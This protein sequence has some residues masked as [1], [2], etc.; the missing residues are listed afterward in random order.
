MARE[1]VSERSG[2]LCRF[3]GKEISSAR[4]EALP[5]V[6]G[7]GKRHVRVQALGA[8]DRITLHTAQRD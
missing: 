2:R 8:G 1:T 5:D 3:C 4:L 6:E 7:D